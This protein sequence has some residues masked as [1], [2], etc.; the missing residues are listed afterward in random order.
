MKLDD[1]GG[2]LAESNIQPMDIFM[3]ALIA[4]VKGRTNAMLSAFDTQTNPA[5]NTQTNAAYKICESLI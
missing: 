1:N 5:F 3:L 4:H 2:I